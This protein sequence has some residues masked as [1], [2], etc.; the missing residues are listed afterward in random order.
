MSRRSEG[1][2]TNSFNCLSC[3][4]SP[5]PAGGEQIN[6][7]KTN[8]FAA[9][10]APRRAREKSRLVTTTVADRSNGYREMVS[11][12]IRRQH[13]VHQHLTGSSRNHNLMQI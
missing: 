6:L 2:E 11:G 9:F 4:Q 5:A 12:A 7:R 8:I 10:D 3:H 13:D 1:T